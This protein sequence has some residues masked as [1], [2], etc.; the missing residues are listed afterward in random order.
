M[1]DTKLITLAMSPRLAALVAYVLDQ[2][3]DE[4][5][6]GGGIEIFGDPE[7]EAIHAVIREIDAQGPIKPYDYEDWRDGARVP[8]TPAP[9]QPV[10][11]SQIAADAAEVADRMAKASAK[12]VES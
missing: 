1:T 8:G 2:A 10:A 3:V 6:Y 12:A 4:A 9:T 11:D 5:E 7:I